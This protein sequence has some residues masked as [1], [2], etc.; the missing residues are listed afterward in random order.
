MKKRFSPG[1]S[2]TPLPV[3]LTRRRI[4]ILPTRHGVLFLLVL[5]GMLL[6]SINYNNNLG[7]LL[8]FLL[9]GMVLVSIIH[10]WRNLLGL[11]VLSVSAAPVFAGETAVFQVLTRVETLLRKGVSLGFENAARILETI[12]PGT[13]TNAAL[14]WETERRGLYSP[15]KLIIATR[16]PLG[17]FRAWANLNTEAAVVV[18][19]QP[20]AGALDLTDDM[21]GG[22]ADKAK[23]IRGV[24]DFKG[25]K[26]Y[27]P[28][29]AIQHIA[30][31]TLSRGQGV[32]TKEFGGEER[33]SVMLDYAAVPAEDTE[34]RLSRL[35]DMVLQAS[36][37][38]L[39]Y[40]LKLPGHYLPPDK[41]ERHK[42]ECL[43]TLALFQTDE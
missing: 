21:A 13:E 12:A 35:T 25:L 10:T 8:V 24:D 5:F 39:A 42:Q 17:L 33:S 26:Q 40:G 23:E 38:Q 3:R 16:F 37:R 31:K 1:S 36:Q 43:K 30:W 34:Y 6:G 14:T 18:Y 29:D 27:Q 15:G 9:G 2:D 11:K 41:G 28:G 32:F 20:L 7:F 4:Y 19:P 22:D